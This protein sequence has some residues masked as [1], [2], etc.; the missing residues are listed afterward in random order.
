MDADG[1]EEV[2]VEGDA[3]AVAAEEAGVVGGEDFDAGAFAAADAAEEG[4]GFV[5]GVEVEDGGGV[6]GGKGVEEGEAGAIKGK[7]VWAAHVWNHGPCV[8][9]GQQVFC[10]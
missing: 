5:G 9:V 2:A 4:G 6:A 1:F 10:M 7:D 8:V 3:G